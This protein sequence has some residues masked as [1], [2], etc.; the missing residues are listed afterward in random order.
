MGTE[1]HPTATPEPQPR[2]RMERSER[3]VAAGDSAVDRRAF[4][5]SEET[6]L[7]ELYL[8]QLRHRA[9]WRDSSRR[10]GGTA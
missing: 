9:G 8:A 10:H 7:V 6:G 2:A 3:R 4:R 5:S 1:K